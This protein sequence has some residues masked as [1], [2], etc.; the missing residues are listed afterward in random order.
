MRPFLDL[1]D[2]RA[3]ITSGM[4][5]AGKATVERFRE[6]G[7]SVLTTARHALSGMDAYG[8]ITADLSHAEGCD[9]VTKAVFEKLGGFD[10]IVHMLG[11]SS[12]PAGGFEAPD[13][14]QWQAKIDLNLMPAVRLDRALVPAMVARGSGVMIHVTS[15]QREMPLKGKIWREPRESPLERDGG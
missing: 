1:A 8:F 12:A 6:L 15:I 2:K 5:G 7:A 13:D 11:G 10:I 14:A 3:L 4:R 9:A